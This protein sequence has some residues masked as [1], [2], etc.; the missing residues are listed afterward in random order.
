MHLRA[1]LVLLAMAPALAGCA[2]APPADVVT[3]GYSTQF[4][5]ERIAGGEL[6]VANLARPGVEVHDFEPTPS[7]LNAMRGARLL[8]VHGYG[9]EGWLPD[10]RAALAGSGVQI[11]EVGRVAGGASTLTIDEGG[12]QVTDP[13]TW[14]DPLSYKESAKAVAD[15]MAAAV[16]AHAAALRTNLAALQADLDRLDGELSAGL[17]HCSRPTIVTNHLAYGY[18][19]R[20]YGFRVVA[21]HGFAPDGDVPPSAVRDA[22]DTIRREHVPTIFVEEGTD[23]SFEAS[24]RAVREE[25][26]VSVQE[27][28]AAEVQPEV[29]S[30]FAEMRDG[31][32]KLKDAMACA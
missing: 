29:G 11:V 23:P 15:A 14:L 1:L 28:G 10:A 19:A 2:K 25:T 27:L 12:E 21:L 8:L 18:L 4:L 17:A 13:H 24:I 30:Y 22:I 16:P 26:G 6:S 20:R 7:D 31:L 9:L 32:A 5:A 3:A